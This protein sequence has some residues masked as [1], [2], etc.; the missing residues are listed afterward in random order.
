MM[1]VRNMI[2]DALPGA[3]DGTWRDITNVNRPMSEAEV[4]ALFKARRPTC[5]ASYGPAA[6]KDAI[7]ALTTI[8]AIE[9]YDDHRLAIGR[10]QTPSTSPAPGGFFD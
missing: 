7:E 3:H 8:S 5:R 10:A 4:I 1:A 2:A 6:H 9:T